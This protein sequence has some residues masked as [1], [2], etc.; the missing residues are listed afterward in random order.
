[1]TGEFE[2]FGLA[3]QGDYGAAPTAGCWVAVGEE[4][5]G[6]LVRRIEDWLCGIRVE[7]W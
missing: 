7:E 2:E 3:A 5:V 4:G 1:M 6:R